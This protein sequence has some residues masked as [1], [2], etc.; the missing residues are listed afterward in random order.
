MCIQMH[1]LDREIGTIVDE[2]SGVHGKRK[3]S[4]Q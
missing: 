3:A 1:L 4:K 2:L